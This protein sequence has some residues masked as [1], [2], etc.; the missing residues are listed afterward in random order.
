MIELILFLIGAIFFMFVILMSCILYK[1]KNKENYSILNHFPFELNKEIWMIV[2]I[3]FIVIIFI[4]SSSM[5]FLI[6]PTN[7]VN[8]FL[9]NVIGFIFIINYLL[10]FSI[11]QIKI[12]RSFKIYNIIA[13]LFS[14][15]TFS[16]DLFG[17]LYI[18]RS[19]NFNRLY[20]IP[21]IVLL[22]MKLGFIILTLIKGFETND[23]IINREEIIYKR[24]K[25]I[26]LC[27][28]QWSSIILLLVSNFIYLIML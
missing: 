22:V 13:S 5:R 9:S 15:L 6:N 14:S 3:L 28:L 7:H 19:D 1:V 24:K 8:Y 12:E 4:I 21:F 16:I 27:L 18:L 25:V 2:S 11:F 10:M 20:F 17:I 23:K 26:S